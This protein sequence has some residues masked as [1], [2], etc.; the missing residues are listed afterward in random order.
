MLAAWC[1]R[2]VDGGLAGVIWVVPFLMGGRHALGQLILVALAVVT[3][4]AWAI[5]QTVSMRAAWRPSWA[6]WLI[7]G[8]AALLLLQIAPLPPAVLKSLAPHQAALLPLWASGGSSGPALGL[9][10]T[11]S[12][13]PADTRAALV[14]FLAYALLFLVAAERIRRIEDVERLLRWCA[15]SAIAMALLGLAQLVA[16]NGKFLWV[17]THPYSA[18]YGAA[19]GSFSNRNHF[20]HFLALGIG[21]LIWWLQATQRRTR[22][23]QSVAA[24]DRFNR[25]ETLRTMPLVLLVLAVVAVSFAGMMSLSRGGI[26]AFFLAT[27]VCV[28]V[29]GRNASI[30]K[31][32]IVGMGSAALLFGVSLAIFGNQQVSQRLEDLSSGSVEQL[33]RGAGRRSIWAATARATTDYLPLG[34]GAGSFREVYPMYVDIPFLETVEYTHS[35]N[36]YLQIALETGVAGLVL[37]LA[38][39]GL[40]AAWC[41][42]GL[43]GCDSDRTKACVGAIAGSL[44]ASAVHAMVDFVWY[45]PACTAMV[46]LLAACAMRARELDGER[47][48]TPTRVF[49]PRISRAA[50]AMAVMVLGMWMIWDR[51]GP[52]LAAPSWDDYL[53]ARAELDPASSPPRPGDLTSSLPAGRNVLEVERWLISRLHDVVYWDRDNA[54]AHLELAECHLRLFEQLQRRAE[55]PMSLAN[56]RDAAIQSR[57]CSREALKQWLSQAVGTH[58]DHLPQALQHIRQAL[59][60]SPLQGRGYVYLAELCFLEEAP[61]LQPGNWIEQ[62]LLV[63]PHDGE[64]LYA[65]ASEAWRAGK[66]QLWLECSRRAF[67][68]GPRQQQRVIDDLVGNTP[69]EATEQLV[70]FIVREFQPDLEALRLLHESCSRRFHPDRLASL[71]RYQA[72]AAVAR[73]QTLDGAMAAEAW[74]EAL[75]LYTQ[76]R[77]GDLALQCARSALRCDPDNYNVRYHLAII[78]ADREAWSEAEPHLFWCLQRSGNSPELASRYKEALRRKLE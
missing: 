59:R 74:I 51:I 66:P 55:N 56:L 52:T 65:A 54:R 47:A 33:D 71:C 77:Q 50:V 27:A 75:T 68:S 41:I 8:G 2:I 16:G 73:A 37:T 45:V 63:R 17:Y 5:R 1:L 10:R 7:F 4:L 11:V 6:T 60:L 36:C 46:V 20:A 67:R 19:T 39:V 14:L 69:P 44:A 58:L 3:A 12:L 28:A 72:Q 13:A 18:T 78:L 9:W 57:F 35:E 48:I 76:L 15:I 24:G 29:C 25:A 38:G 40:C 49:L 34:S 22:A 70:E 53:L 23:R 26:A 21:P 42:A 62:A 32:L 31:S 64:V 43:G 61:N 30:R